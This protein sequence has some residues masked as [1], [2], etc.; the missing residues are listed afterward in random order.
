MGENHNLIINGSGSYGGGTYEKIKIRGDGTITSDFDCNVFKAYGSSN[1][2][3]NGNAKRF[4]VLGE[5]E[6][7][8]DLNAAELK[9]LGTA[10]VGGTAT[11]KRMKVWGTL[12]IGTRISGE[13][14]NIKGSLSVNG[15]AEFENFYSTGAFEIKGLLNAETIKIF[16][17]YGSSSAEEIGGEKIIVKRKS[18][19]FSLF[20]GEGILEAGVIEGDE[21]YLENTTANIVR[22]KRISIGPGCEIGVVEYNEELSVDPNAL[23]K[24]NR[25]MC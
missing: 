14:A 20:S 17:R 25:K 8:G 2:L 3:K 12:D 13:D 4:D 7:C 11:I 10:S 5:T 6:I 9:I 22:G 18:T 1:I 16:P 23:V 19:L 15:D 21:V 24:E